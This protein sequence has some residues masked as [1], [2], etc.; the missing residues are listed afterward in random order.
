[1][2]AAFGCVFLS[3]TLHALIAGQAKPPF[4][5]T[6]WTWADR[7]ALFALVIGVL[8]LITATNFY[9]AA[10]CLQSARRLGRSA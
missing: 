1:F 10:E 3:R 7:P 8:V 6:A 9:L 4:A 5:S 2:Y